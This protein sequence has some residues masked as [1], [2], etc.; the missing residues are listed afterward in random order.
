MNYKKC[1]GARSKQMIHATTAE[2]LATTAHQQFM[3]P[4]TRVI[5]NN[6]REFASQRQDSLVILTLTMQRV[7]TA[8]STLADSSDTCD[9]S[10]G[11][12]PQHRLSMDT[13]SPDTVLNCKDVLLMPALLG[14]SA[15]SCKLSIAAAVAANP[16]IVPEVHVTSR[17]T[18]IVNIA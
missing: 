7:A 13:T 1:I 17:A 14:P 2:H 11:D 6:L 18:L 3:D 10:L 15:S 16:S 9:T 5:A 12:S 4:R 8:G